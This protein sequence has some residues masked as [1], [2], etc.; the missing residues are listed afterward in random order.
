MKKFA[1]CALCVMVLTAATS[2]GVQQDDL[3]SHPGYF[4]LEELD[5]LA[6]AD[7]KVDV[8]LSGAMIRLVVAA[9]KNEDPELSN[10]L[11]ELKRI[12]VI[13]GETTS[14]DLSQIM[15]QLDKAGQRLASSGWSVILKV[16]DDE[17][18]VRFMVR[19][20]DGVIDGMTVLYVDGAEDVAMINIVGR[21]DPAM[22]GRLGSTFGGLPDL[23]EF[24]VD[25]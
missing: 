16:R 9:T 19:E 25:R 1:F 14:D 23:D 20:T 13:V 8:N 10:M 22:I 21:M 24:E 12:R 11:S 2:L 15:S 7:V 4:P 17:E 3:E 5:L 18:L 6:P